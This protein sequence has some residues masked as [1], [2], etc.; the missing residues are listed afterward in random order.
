MRSIHWLVE[1][2]SSPQATHMITRLVAGDLIDG[3]YRIERE[4]GKGG[5]GVV[6][7]AQ[8][9]L[10]GKVVALKMM[11]AACQIDAQ[12]LQRFQK[13]AKVTL[14]LCHP[15][16]VMV[17][18]FGTTADECPYIVMD[19]LEGQSL[20]KMIRSGKT[21][22]KAVYLNLALQ[23]ADG[24]AHAHLK[25]VIHRDLKTS[26]VFVV[27]ESEQDYCA[28]VVDFGIAKLM[29]DS[30]TGLTRTGEI[31]GTP[32]YI[33]PEQA[34]GQQVDE[35]SDIY[36]FGCILYEMC[37]GAPPFQGDNMLCVMTQHVHAEPAQGVVPDDIWGVIQRCLAKNP[38]DRYQSFEQV[39]EDIKLVLSGA[40][41]KHP[42]GKK[43]R[44]L[45]V[46]AVAA[47]ILFAVSIPF[48][49]GGNIRDA[50]S[51]WV[52]HPSANDYIAD[53]IELTRRGQFDQAIDSCEKAISRD[54]RSYEARIEE[55]FISMRMDKYFDAVK[56]LSSA[57][58]INPRSPDALL[59]RGR[60][61]LHTKDFTGALD[62]L[63]KLVTFY[64]EADVSSD[65]GLALQSLG[66][67]E[68][69]I[70][71]F[72][73]ALQRRPNDPEVLNNRAISRAAMKE[74]RLALEDLK[75]AIDL[76][77]KSAATYATRSTVY[78]SCNRLKEAL[79]DANLAVEL[80]PHW[81]VSY[82]NRGYIYYLM[83]ENEK[84]QADIDKAIALNPIY[85]EAYASRGDLF[86]SMG[87]VK[88]ALAD[89]ER[90]LRINP[91]NANA[92]SGKQFLKE[93]PAGGRPPQLEQLA[94][95][96]NAESEK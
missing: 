67:H 73:A 50:V 16:V 58:K 9:M 48:T 74:Y 91:C 92:L 20:E 86:A 3:K 94:S 87:R 70:E 61:R 30:E 52:K 39:S 71:D 6:Y 4:I 17:R 72:T 34:M 88:E 10:L 53:A 15:N 37:S 63:T 35:R 46:Y 80:A 29:S 59:G 83:H 51:S 79:S 60:A 41:L 90:A 85:D 56:Y 93:H 75:T 1:L 33:S 5:M 45:K 28:K 82:N 68:Q 13:E 57:L 19:F 95:E 26:N 7:Q 54:P 65:R 64:P 27:G 32:H 8:H 47:C 66:K 22:D 96:M 21:R 23:I 18:E 43:S 11:Q 77:P 84:A 38:L 44:T 36:S 78:L 25:R 49:V 40:A 62:D 69:A 76:R 31:V 2:E 81:F 14:E 12:T 24:M 89:Y 42:G 55:G